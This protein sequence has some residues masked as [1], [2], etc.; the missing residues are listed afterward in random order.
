MRLERGVSLIELVV[1][2]AVMGV[3]VSGL[4]SSWAMLNSHNADP[5]VQRQA[6]AVAESLMQEISLQP[7]ATV[8]GTGGTN[9]SAFTSIADYDGLTLN[10]IT[11]AQGVSL[12]GLAGYV[13][14]VSVGPQSLDGVPS[15][16]G[17]WIEVRVTSPAGSDTV[18]SGWR[19]AH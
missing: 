4:W 7:V 5:L 15:S 16:A 14:R 17:W 19:A 1:S 13:A 10:G 18:L 12:P 3:L 2:I 8:S 9:R 6:L 11:D